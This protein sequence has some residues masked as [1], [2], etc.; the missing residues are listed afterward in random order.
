MPDKDKKKK[1]PTWLK[2]LRLNEVSLVG[3]GANQHANVC[4]F[5][6][7]DDPLPNKEGHMADK[8]ELEKALDDLAKAQ[9][10]IAGLNLKVSGLDTDLTKAQADLRSRE[11]DLTDTRTD[12]TR[13]LTKNADPEE[14]LLKGM[15]EP[16]KAAFLAQKATN[17][18]LV[19]R[20]EK[21]F[22][23]LPVK[24][25]DFAPIMKMAKANLDDEQ[26]TELNRI[27][28]AGSEALKDLE[29]MKGLSNGGQAPTSAEDK[30]EKMAK[31]RAGK[32]NITFEQ[33]YSKVLNDNPDLY[34]DFDSERGYAQ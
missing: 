19:K 26:M 7:A 27:L 17:E 16:A 3:Q 11:R 6:S 12:L 9:G 33:A 24:A 29:V 4:L 23:G 28:K 14:E 10:D 31:E 15:S 18:K 8:T 34:L 13:E 30:L 5:K 2:N 25:D 21:D 20:L 22:A 1:K 32:D